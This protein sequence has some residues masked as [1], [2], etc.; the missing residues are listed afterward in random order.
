MQLGRGVR[1]SKPTR[2]PTRMNVAKFLARCRSMPGLA[3]LAAAI[4]VLLDDQDAF[5]TEQNDVFV[6]EHGSS[7]ASAAGC[8]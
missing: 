6:A 4:L 7:A 1:D 8:H 2:S 5:L 3:A